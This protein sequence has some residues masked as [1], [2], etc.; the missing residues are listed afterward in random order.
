MIVTVKFN[1]TLWLSSFSIIHQLNVAAVVCLQIFCYQHDFFL[2]RCASPRSFAYFLI[3]SL[4]NCCWQHSKYHIHPDSINRSISFY[5]PFFFI[6]FFIFYVYAFWGNRFTVQMSHINGFI[7]LRMQTVMLSVWL[8]LNRILLTVAN[9]RR[10]NVC[11]TFFVVVGVVV[12]QIQWS[13]IQRRNFI[14]K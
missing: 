6:I 8:Y 5:E 12:I 2:F 1:F 10:I 3:L 11:C 4:L 7:F 9:A 14:S 13:K